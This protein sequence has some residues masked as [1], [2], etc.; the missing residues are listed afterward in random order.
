[1]LSKRVLIN[2][3]VF[4]GLSFGLVLYGAVTLLGNPLAER[5]TATAVFPDASGILEDFS[6]SM[7]GV[8]IGQ[9]TGVELE[10]DAARV[11]VS[12]GPGGELPGDVQA[13]IVR[14]S[15]VGEQRIEFTPMR[16]GDEPPLP[17]GAEVPVIADSEPPQISRVIDTMN[18]L[19][20][21]IPP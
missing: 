1:M 4:F 17:D 3:G 7:N 8:V 9:V 14:A 21:A 20:E 12:L 6:A 5:R 16:G 11:T 13:S 2:L 15:A 19:L 10:G 18:G